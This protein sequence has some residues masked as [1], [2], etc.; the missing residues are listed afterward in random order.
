MLGR[1]RMPPNVRTVSPDWQ[2]LGVIVED[3]LT[4]ALMDLKHVSAPLSK[5]KGGGPPSGSGSSSTAPASSETASTSSSLA[6]T[7]SY[8]TPDDIAA[9]AE[10][11]AELIDEE[12]W[13]EALKFVIEEHDLTSRAY[14]NM[15]DRTLQALSTYA[16]VL[17]QLGRGSDTRELLEELVDRRTQAVASIDPKA[18]ADE[19]TRAQDLLADALLELSTVLAELEEPLLA[20]PLLQRALEIRETALG[21]FSDQSLLIYDQLA[22]ALADGGMSVAAVETL[23]KSLEVKRTMHGAVSLEVAEGHNELAVALQA[24][25]PRLRRPPDPHASAARILCMQPAAHPIRSARTAPPAPAAAAVAPARAPL[26][27]ADVI[28][29]SALSASRHALAPGKHLTCM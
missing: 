23:R 3:S 25:A 17:W 4:A 20:V 2:P 12:S 22:R 9:I 24:R 26:Q 6:G 7:R 10:R 14:G 11:A 1:S 8:V 29:H 13:E 18:G 15:D 5:V 28:A 27:S 21:T 16:G 19:L